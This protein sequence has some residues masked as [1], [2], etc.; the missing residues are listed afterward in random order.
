[1][2]IRALRLYLA[3]YAGLQR[4]VLQSIDPIVIPGG[5]A[6][7]STCFVNLY[8]QTTILAPVIIGTRR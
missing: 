8:L 6:Q 1:M 3:Y 4:E 5:K 7:C 2:N